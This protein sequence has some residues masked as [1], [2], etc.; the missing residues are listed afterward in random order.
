LLGGEARDPEDDAAPWSSMGFGYEAGGYVEA[1]RNVGTDEALGTAARVVQ[2]EVR[3][4]LAHVYETQVD[5]GEA[6]FVKD[7]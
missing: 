4:L 6:E 1:F 7:T 3:C 2:R 5:A